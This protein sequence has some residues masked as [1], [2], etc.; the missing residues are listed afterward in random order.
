MISFICYA[1]REKSTGYF[2]PMRWRQSSGFSH[3]EPEPGFPRLF[4]SKESARSALSSWRRGI[5]KK[6]VD[7]YDGVF[8]PEYDVHVGVS[9]VPERL[10]K[11]MEIVEMT[12]TISSPELNSYLRIGETQS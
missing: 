12:L 7:R 4:P 5:W 8:G 1:I 2:L 10:N 9:P 3:D 11:D 6:E